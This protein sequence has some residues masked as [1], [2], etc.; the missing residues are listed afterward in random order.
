MY[1]EV[2]VLPA[3]AHPE[4]VRGLVLLASG[5]FGRPMSEA[6]KRA[7]EEMNEVKLTGDLDK[8]IELNVNQ[9]L[10]GPGQPADRTSPV[11]Q[12]HFKRM[13]RHTFTKKQVNNVPGSV[14]AIGPVFFLSYNKVTL[15]TQQ[16]K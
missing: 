16:P 5:L 14:E 13:L 15:K 2:A 3:L 11:V 4:R 12:E 9:W 10:N 6:R 7:L 8:I 1:A